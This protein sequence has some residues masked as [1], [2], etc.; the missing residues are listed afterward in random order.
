MH[1]LLVIGAM[2]VAALAL[3]GPAYAWSWPADGDVLRPFALA[4]DAYAA[5]QHRGIDVAGAAGSSIRAP[6]TGTVSFAGSLPT[7]G[8]SL[9]ILTPDGYAVTLV[10]LG[11]VEV[12]KGDAVEEGSPVATMGSSGEPEHPVPSV[13]LGVRVASQEEGYVDPLGL[14]PP[15]ATAP[16]P[17]APAPPPP[18]ATTP[19]VPSAAAAPSGSRGCP[20]ARDCSGR[21][22]RRGCAGGVG[23]SGAA[24][25]RGTGRSRTER[26]VADTGAV[27]VGRLVPAGARP[28]CVRSCLRSDGDV[29]DGNRPPHNDRRATL[30]VR[31]V[32]ASPPR[33]AAGRRTARIADDRDG[34]PRGRTGPRGADSSGRSLRSWRTCPSARRCA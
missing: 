10:H 24:R 30:G 17:Q 8:R 5:G 23:R 28:I 19:P 29:L 25:R 14:L 27:A 21:R 22:F 33:A 2:S 16:R 15:R 13:H 20:V 6:A 9:T 26:I 34:G 32:G 31:G 7:Y 18:V 11:T 1:R 3:S 12:A 4:G